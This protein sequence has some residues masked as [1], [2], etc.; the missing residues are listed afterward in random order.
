LK[1]EKNNYHYVA[2]T[3]EG[4]EEVLERE[5]I[6][7]GARN[8]RILTHAVSFDGDKSL[9]YAANFR[10]RTALR[11][12]RHVT[13]FSFTSEMEFYKIL[14]EIR[15]E[16]YITPEQH[17]S[18]E[19][20]TADSFMSNVR[21]IEQKTKEAI[22]DRFRSIYGQRPAV[23]NFNPDLLINI[24]IA[25]DICQVFADSSCESLH[26]RG[27]RVTNGKDPLNEVLAAGMILMSGWDHR[28]DF[29]DPMCGSGTLL[30]EA[31]MI[32]NNIPAGSYR[33]DYGFMHWKDYDKNL[34]QRVM[35]AGFKE[36]TEADIQ[37]CGS[38]ASEENLE[39]GIQNIRAAKLHKDIFVSLNSLE[40]LDPDIDQPGIIMTDLPYDAQS[41]ASEVEALYRMIGENLKQ[42]FVGFQA[43]ILSGNYS[44][45]AQFDLKPSKKITLV[46]GHTECRFMKFDLTEENKKVSSS[47]HDEATEIDFS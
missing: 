6:V 12:L 17:I 9:M 34:Y 44:A 16:Q 28:S 47:K 15:W 20:T 33:K 5:L 1:A 30:I 31:A 29:F 10:C 42:K 4:L 18:V 40:D 13:S 35:E 43:W 46:N 19:A 7:L 14:N 25:E 32:A 39:S 37:I 11:I 22:V 26:H 3:L 36:Q 8:T 27:Y 45:M 21:F 38:D 2:K 23:N 24:N 41:D